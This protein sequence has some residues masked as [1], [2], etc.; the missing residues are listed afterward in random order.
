[1]TFQEYGE[2]VLFQ[3]KE[4]Q[5]KRE[6]TYKRIVLFEKYNPVPK[7]ES[8]FFIPVREDNQWAAENN[9]NIPENNNPN[10]WNF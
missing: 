3:L 5:I 8:D 2:R 7:F 6:R 9:L 10:Q 1:M 4:E